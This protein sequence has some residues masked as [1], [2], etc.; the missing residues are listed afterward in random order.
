VA[1]HLAALFGLDPERTEPQ[2]VKF[3]LSGHIPVEG[4]ARTPDIMMDGNIG[5]QFLRHWDL[6]LDLAKGR[7]W[8]APAEANP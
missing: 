8:L 2:P 1:K 7:V 5:L 3:E 4:V 6:T